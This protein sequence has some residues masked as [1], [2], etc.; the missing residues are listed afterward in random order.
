MFEIWCDI[1]YFVE[2][3]S[4]TL[5]LKVWCWDWKFD[6]EIESLTKI[7]WQL[8]GIQTLN[9]I[10]YWLNWLVMRC[11]IQEWLRI[12]WNTKVWTK[13]V[14]NWLRSMHLKWL[15]LVEI[16]CGWDSKWY[17]TLFYDWPWDVESKVL[18]KSVENWLR[19]KHLKWLRLVEILSGIIC[20]AR[21]GHEI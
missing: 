14:E 3:E 15:R 5:R 9:K 16:L 2:I 8:T 21:I 1:I 19:F 7:G 18:K 10:D 4:L 12:D 20:L 11:R 6:I 17:H 13:L